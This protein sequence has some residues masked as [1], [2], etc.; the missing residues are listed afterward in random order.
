MRIL[1]EIEPANL[2]ALRRSI[3]DTRPVDS[4][5]LVEVTPGVFR[6]K[7]PRDA[8]PVPLDRLDVL[9]AAGALDVVDEAFFGS[10]AA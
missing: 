9:R 10:E 4:A 5:A 6:L 8:I 7:V 2:E 3:E 1:L